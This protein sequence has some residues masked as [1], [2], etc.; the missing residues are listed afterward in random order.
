MIEHVKLYHPVWVLERV[1][2]LRNIKAE[3]A[4][5]KA[6]QQAQRERVQAER[7]KARAA[8]E[9]NIS[10][11]PYTGL[12][13][14]DLS[15]AFHDTSAYVPGN[16]RYLSQFSSPQPSRAPQEQSALQMAPRD[17]TGASGTAGSRPTS[18]YA[19]TSTSSH[20]T[21]HPQKFMTAEE[22]KKLADSLVQAVSP[23]NI[24]QLATKLQQATSSSA[25]PL[26]GIA[27]PYNPQTLASN[28]YAV[29][30]TQPSSVTEVSVVDN[31]IQESLKSVGPQ[32]LA[33]AFNIVAGTA[34]AQSR[35]GRSSPAQP[36]SARQNNPVALNTPNFVGPSSGGQ[37][38]QTAVPKASRPNLPVRM[39][40][41]RVLPNPIFPPK[42]VRSALY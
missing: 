15:N 39:T 16:K 5:R 33:R 14:G 29:P 23:E 1:N 26:E 13:G 37:Q 20:R 41:G 24:A 32:D 12:D 18:A 19:S 2:V 21:S 38:Q 8:R 22:V 36:N 9:A 27:K 25:R 3:Q 31:V 40:A 17:Y 28:S 30:R 6:E 11:S 34:S 42:Q 7:Q 4:R 35:Y 10:L